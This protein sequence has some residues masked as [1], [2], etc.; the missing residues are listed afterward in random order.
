MFPIP[1]SAA[2]AITS[3][4]IGTIMSTP[5]IE[6]R[7]LPGKVRCRKRSNA[8]TW[9]SRSS[10]AIGSIGSAGARNRPNSAACRSQRR[11]SGTKTCA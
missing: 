11:S 9:V 2:S 8:S 5:S 1:A 6:K 4:R 10:S 7:V 3:S